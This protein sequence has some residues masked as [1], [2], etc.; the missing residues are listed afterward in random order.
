MASRVQFRDWQGLEGVWQNVETT[1]GTFSCM[2][3]ARLTG[4]AAGRSR[5]QIGKKPAKNKA[6]CLMQ[7]VNVREKLSIQ[8]AGLLGWVVPDWLVWRPLLSSLHE[9]EKENSLSA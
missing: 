8:G 1:P 2:L 6:R 9:A 4:Y 3:M 7:E 5:H